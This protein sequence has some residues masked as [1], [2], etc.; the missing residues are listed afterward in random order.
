MNDLTKQR[1]YN[2][3]IIRAALLDAQ[4]F[5]LSMDESERVECPLTHRF[6]P[7]LYCR[8]LVVPADTIVMGKIHKKEHIC[9][10]NG[11][12]EYVTEEGSERVTGF[13]VFITKP[14][15]K[16]LVKTYTD[17]TFIT[18]HPTETTDVDELEQELVALT[19]EDYDNYLIN[20]TNNKI[21]VSS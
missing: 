21:G 8:E 7:G 20:N 4:D 1:V 18:F 13:R 17:T 14:G 16:R 12:F 11:D 19:Y 5:M 10:A 6:T 2:P 9:I 3:A 15:I